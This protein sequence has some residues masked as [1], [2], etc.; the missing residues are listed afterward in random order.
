L[1]ERY[2]FYLHTHSSVLDLTDPIS[3]RTFVEKIAASYHL[4][5][6]K[7]L[8]STIEVVQFNFSRRRDLTSFDIS[9][10]EE[11]WSDV[12]V[13]ARR[14]GEHKGDLEAIMLQL[15]TPF[16]N[17]EPNY[18]SDW[19]DSTTDYQFLYLRFKEIGQCAQNLHGSTAAL[20]SLTRSRQAFKAQ[21]LSLQATERLIRDRVANKSVSQSSAKDI[22]Q[23][24]GLF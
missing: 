12:Q 20:A 24:N 8:Q 19:R 21:E 3:S 23:L 16:E 5:L 18:I 14:I 22:F 15:G 10:V 2:I 13:L 17:P 6:A 1:L 4:K 7:F 9:A 11:Q